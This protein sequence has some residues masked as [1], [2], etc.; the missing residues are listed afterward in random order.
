LKYIVIL[1][2]LFFA[3]GCA[4][5][6][7][8]RKPNFIIIFADDLGYGD[9]GCYGNAKNRT[10]NID[11]MAAEGVRFTDFYA[12]SSVCTP[13]RASLLTG[14]YPKRIGMDVSSEPV[15]TPG[16]Q[17]LYPMAKKGLNPTE[18]TIADAL[19]TMGYATACIGKW[20]LGD[21][22][23]FLP[24]KQG[25]DYFY[26]IPYSNDMDLEDCPLPL[27][28]NTDIIEAPVQQSNLTQQYTRE[29]IAF[30]EGNKDNPF[31]IYL[32]H[33]MVHA[34]LQASTQFKDKSG[35]GIYADAVEEL[36]W[37]TGKILEYLKS[38]GLSANTMV[39]FV[40][41]N[42]ASKHFKGTNAPLRGFKA[43]SWE[44][45]FRV[46]AIFWWPGHILEGSTTDALSSTMDLFPTLCDLSG[47]S[48]PN[49][50]IDGKS[51][52]PLLEGQ[53]TESPNNYFNY[54]QSDQLMAVR[55]DD[56][57]LHLPLDSAYDDAFLGTF[58]KN[59]PMALYNMKE[60]IGEQNDVSSKHPEV[61]KKLLAEA[62]IVRKDL[63]DLNRM[64]QHTRLA[65]MA[66]HVPECIGKND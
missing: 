5:Q 51:I 50:K 4:Q 31:F 48:L 23:E 38:S 13:S 7:E 14:C 55:D 42:G 52:W 36:D 2:G 22:P 45:G 20:H 56:W 3:F 40:S 66:E 60:D 1:I 24:T 43:T 63:G 39:I 44:G 11:N 26:G 35:Y 15:G 18:V 53:T 12:S 33:T 6:D 54:Y 28:R 30:M 21:Q 59:R 61:V 41:D 62:E 65:G 10:P 34:P 49:A 17:V 16:R 46:P 19:K 37:S 64:G 27:M 9:L 32:P 8:M 47:A 29:T 25:F 58:T 57:K